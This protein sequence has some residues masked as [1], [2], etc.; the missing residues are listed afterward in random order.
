MIKAFWMGKKIQKFRFKDGLLE[1]EACSVLKEGKNIIKKYQGSFILI[2]M[3]K[4]ISRLY[5]L[6]YNKHKKLNLGFCK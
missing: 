5:H 1:N 2:K 3:S 6:H 4:L